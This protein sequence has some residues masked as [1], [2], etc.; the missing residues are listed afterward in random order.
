MP[1]AAKEGLGMGGYGSE[2][3]ADFDTTSLFQRYHGWLAS[4][5]QRAG[6]LSA[7][8]CPLIAFIAERRIKEC[9]KET[10]SRDW[11]AVR[12]W[13]PITEAW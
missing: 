13:T 11:R 1:S 8:L 2:V 10:A 6:Q 7:A 12:Y 3:E 9:E 5:Y 4:L